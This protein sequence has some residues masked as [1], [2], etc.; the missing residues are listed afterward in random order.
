MVFCITA[1]LKYGRSS[2]WDFALSVPKIR[3]PLDPDKQ[4]AK[5]GAQYCNSLHPPKVGTP[6]KTATGVRLE[7]CST[8]RGNAVVEE[9][10]ISNGLWP[11]G[12]EE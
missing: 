7:S 1:I 3:T 2:T 4:K 9:T 5:D 11:K 10:P 6:T 12:P 8:A